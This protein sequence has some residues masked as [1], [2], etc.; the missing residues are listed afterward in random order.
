MIERRSFLLHRLRL[1]LGESCHVARGRVWFPNPICFAIDS[2]SRPGIPGHRY[3][4]Q[5][6]SASCSSLQEGKKIIQLS[7]HVD[8]QRHP[9]RLLQIM[10]NSHYTNVLDS[11]FYDPSRVQSPRPETPEPYVRQGRR[12]ASTGVQLLDD[13]GAISEKVGIILSCFRFSGITNLHT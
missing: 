4:L 7:V 6:C 8:G 9:A 10:S 11:D 2:T 5:F 12:N 1:R 13:E 3:W